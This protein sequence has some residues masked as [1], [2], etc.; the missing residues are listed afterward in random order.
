MFS[1]GVQ[2]FCFAFRLLFLTKIILF[3]FRLLRYQ[4]LFEFAISTLEFGFA[5]GVTGFF[6]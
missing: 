3:V 6:L 4:S 2:L 5:P 1:G